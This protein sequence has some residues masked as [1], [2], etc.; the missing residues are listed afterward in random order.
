MIPHLIHQWWAGPPLPAVYAARSL[1]LEQAN[2][3]W[4]VH[5]W[6]PESIGPLIAQWHYDEA[7]RYVAAHRVE[8]YRS[9]LVRYELLALFGGVYVDYDLAPV[10]PFTG[11]PPDVLV[12]T[13]GINA[14]PAL[15]GCTPGHPLAAALTAELQR[16]GPLTIRT[17]PGCEQLNEVL[18]SIDVLDRSIWVR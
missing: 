11:L 14:D 7:A 6:G 15:L 1:E 18:G 10:A 3:G 12:T 13:N 16:A 5:R 4:T 17:C 8:V 2:P 9:N